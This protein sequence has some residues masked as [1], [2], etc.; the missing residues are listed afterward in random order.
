MT[1]L[2]PGDVVA[3]L[4]DRRNAVAVVSRAEVGRRQRA[5][6][7]GEAQDV[8]QAARRWKD[9]R[10]ARVRIVRRHY[11]GARTENSGAKLVQQV[12][13]EDAGERRAVLRG[14]GGSDATGRSGIGLGSRHVEAVIGL[15]RER[16]SQPVLVVENVVDA[17]FVKLEVVLDGTAPGE[18]GRVQAI[19]GSEIVGK[20]REGKLFSN[21]AS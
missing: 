20:R 17:S 4:I 8:W 21:Y 13:A 3:P 9:G 16:D 5:G 1:S 10:A 6:E 12:G 18:A 11:F 7:A 19:A 15:M 14:F 2:E